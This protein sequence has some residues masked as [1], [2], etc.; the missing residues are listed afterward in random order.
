MSFS[1]RDSQGVDLLG[2][3]SASRILTPVTLHL[4]QN[5]RPNL[6]YWLVMKGGICHP[7]LVTDLIM[8][9]SY[10]KLLPEQILFVYTIEINCML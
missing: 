2:F 10:H 7:L 4:R 9:H 1:Q 6:E 8:S 3:W 5:L